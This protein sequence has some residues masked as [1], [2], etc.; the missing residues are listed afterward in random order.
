MHAAIALVASLTF[1]VDVGWEVTADNQVEYIIQ[2]NP[3][4]V[5]LL[6]EGEVIRA[7]ILPELAKF[8]R[9]RIQIGRELLPQEDLS[10]VPNRLEVG[11]STT[12]VGYTP[13]TN[14]D[15]AEGDTTDDEP[16]ETPQETPTSPYTQAANTPTPARKPGFLPSNLLHDQRDLAAR[17]SDPDEAEETSPTDD[18]PDVPEDEVASRKPELGH[19]AGRVN[20]DDADEGNAQREQDNGGDTLAVPQPTTPFL[21]AIVGLFA[22]MAGNVY[23]G[24]LHWGL[25]S[26]FREMAA[27]FYPGV[28]PTATSESWEYESDPYAGDTESHEWREVAEAADEQDTEPSRTRHDAVFGELEDAPGT[29]DDQEDWREDE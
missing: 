18:G 3:D 4:E 16:V 13:L 28:G 15:P 1:G 29:R 2:I 23:Q 21:L 5:D 6:R 26:R 11:G 22:S 17:K 7:G 10:D 25:R 19:Q 27:R 9:Y 24:W 20:L 12:R 8:D 14:S